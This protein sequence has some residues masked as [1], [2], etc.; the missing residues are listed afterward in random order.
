MLNCV[1]G[2]LSK[3]TVAEFRTI[4][5]ACDWENGRSTAEAQSAMIKRNEQLPVNSDTARKLGQ[6]IIS[7]LVTNPL[8]V[9]VAVPLHIFPPL[10]NR[11]GPGHQ[12]SAHIDDAVRG[13]PLTGMRIRI[14]LPATLFLSD[15]DE[16]DGG[17]LIVEGHAVKLAAG[18]LALL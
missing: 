2:V 3:A 16:Y 6:R 10:F 7:A 1:P 11:Y 8:F 9:A 17:E 14:D 18:Y 5:D 4:M 12:F 13:D 15:P